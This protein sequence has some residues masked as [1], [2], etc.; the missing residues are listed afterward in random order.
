MF[1][2]IT[3]PYLVPFDG[4]FRREQ[5][6]NLPAG[7]MSKKKLK[8]A[9]KEEV[10][11]LHDLQRVFYAHDRHSLLL[12]F[13]AM[14]AAGKDSTSR[15]VM[16]GVDP[17]GWILGSGSAG[18]IRWLRRVNSPSKSNSPR[19]ARTCCRRARARR[20]DPC[21]KTS[22]ARPSSSDAGRRRPA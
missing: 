2:A 18:P 17:A 22:P 19:R 9:L 13:Q 14:D 20:C 21:R 1:Q 11:R 12:V 6:P 8:K 10:E 5:Y 4:S 16:S 3:S 7:E 15:A